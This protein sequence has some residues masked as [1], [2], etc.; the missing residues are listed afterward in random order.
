MKIFLARSRRQA[1]ITRLLCAERC[2]RCVQLLRRWTRV[3]V[4]MGRY[5]VWWFKTV[6]WHA[7]A[8][9]LHVVYARALRRW[10]V[11][12]MT[13]QGNLQLRNWYTYIAYIY[14]NMYVRVYEHTFIS[15]FIYF[16][17]YFS[18]PLYASSLWSKRY[19]FRVIRCTEQL[20]NSLLPLRPFIIGRICAPTAPPNVW[21]SLGLIGH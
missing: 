3:A 4:A 1:K 17:F 2:A 5:K 12:N 7:R 14:N 13:W 21:F 6:C 10:W 15:L 8:T 20:N 9:G 19:V 16:Y 18:S 11:V